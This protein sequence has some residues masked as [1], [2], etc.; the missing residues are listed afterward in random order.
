MAKLKITAV[1]EK[2]R[3]EIQPTPKG[4]ACPKCGDYMREEEL[5]DI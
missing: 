1:C 5:D 3:V 2:C 4:I